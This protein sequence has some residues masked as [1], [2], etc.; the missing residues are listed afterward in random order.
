MVNCAWLKKLWSTHVMAISLGQ[1]LITCLSVHLGALEGHLMGCWWRLV[2]EQDVGGRLI[3]IAVLQRANTSALVVWWTSTA[4]WQSEKKRIHIR[5]VAHRQIIHLMA[6][7]V[8]F[9]KTIVLSCFF[10]MVVLMGEIA[11]LEARLKIVD[12]C[13]WLINNVLLSVI[14]H[15]RM[16]SL[17]VW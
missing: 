12:P 11:D 16:T 9:V 2:C 14:A 7:Y 1:D 17:L 5:Q 10:S 3:A 8:F 15:H 6:C 4:L 13:W